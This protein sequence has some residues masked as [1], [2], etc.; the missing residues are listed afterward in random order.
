MED[1]GRETENRG[2]H[3][4]EDPQCLLIPFA[5]DDDWNLCIPPALCCGEQYLNGAGEG[6][7]PRERPAGCAC[8]LRDTGHGV[9]GV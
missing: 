4:R 1:R 9:S 6:V 7:W 2:N 5:A 8:Q 3:S